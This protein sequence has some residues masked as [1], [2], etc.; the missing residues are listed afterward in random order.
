MSKKS[1]IAA[2]VFFNKKLKLWDFSGVIR[3][4]MEKMKGIFS[5]PLF[6]LYT[7]IIAI[8]INGVLF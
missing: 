5:L 7:I 4:V 8:S 1:R 3:K 6:V 2:L